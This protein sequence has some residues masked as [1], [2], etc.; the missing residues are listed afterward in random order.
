MPL[1]T[2]SINT[3]PLVGAPTG[4]V[5]FGPRVRCQTNVL[6]M[7]DLLPLRARAIRDARHLDAALPSNLFDRRELL[8]PID[9]GAYHVV[10]IRRAQALGEN[11]LDTRALEHRAHRATGDDA[12]ARS[13]RL[14]EYPA[15]A[16]LSHD[17]VRNRSAGQRQ[18]DAMT[19]RRVDRLANGFRCLIRLAGSDAD[20][21]L[22]VANGHQSVEGE[23]P[24]TLY[25]FGDAIDGDDVL[26]EIAPFALTAR[27]AAA[28][29]AP[30]ATVASATAIASAA[31]TTAATGTSRP[32]RPA[33]TPPAAATTSAASPTGSATA[34]GATTRAATAT[35]AT[36]AALRLR[37]LPAA[38]AAL[39]ILG[40]VRTPIRPHGRHRPLLSRGRDIDIQ[41]GRRR[42][43]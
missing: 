17:L 26:D 6:A 29:T 18:A 10:R 11:V 21:A 36:T 37:R 30:T 4:S 38:F 16:M 2:C 22:P 14:H 34:T 13:R 7:D 20:L 23:P 19:P 28:I 32:T 42:P 24:P 27:S 8:Q 15:R 5:F 43:S 39:L 1:R 9:G 12:S 40:H 25:D 3:R 41:R 35:T 33:T 31:S